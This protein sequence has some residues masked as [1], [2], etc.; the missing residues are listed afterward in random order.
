MLADKKN[1]VEHL[2]DKGIIYIEGKLDE[3]SKIVSESKYNAVE[4]V[5]EAYTDDKHEHN[6]EVTKKMTKDIEFI[7]Y[8]NKD[9]IEM[10]K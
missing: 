7:L 3:L 4:R 9:L 5:I 2:I 10:Q 6:V 1:V 8:N